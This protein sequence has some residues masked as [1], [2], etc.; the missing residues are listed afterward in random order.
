MYILIIFIEIITL[1]ALITI[2]HN[3]R[4]LKQD[5]FRAAVKHSRFLWLTGIVFNGF[6]TW[7][8]WKKILPAILLPVLL[9]TGVAI[10]YIRYTLP[11]IP[12]VPDIAIDYQDSALFK[13][14]RYLA[15]NVAIC[16]DCH[17]PRNVSYF[18]WPVIRNQK[19][20]GGPF[21][22]QKLG[23]TFPGE[24]FTPN[25]TPASLGAWTDGEI[26]R[27][28]TTGI[29]RNGYTINHVMP[30]LSYAQMDPIDIKAIIVYI[31]TLKP[32]SNKPAGITTINYFHSLYNRTLPREVKPIYLSNLKTAIDS[33][34]YLVTVAGC[35]DCHTPKKWLEINDTSR[36]LSGGIEYPLPTGGFVHSANLT[37]DQSGLGT[38][39]EST[40]I[41]KFKR[42]RDSGAIYKPA[43][44]TFNSLMPWSSYRYMTDN[45][46][47][48]IYAYLKSIKPISNPVTIF[49]TQSLKNRK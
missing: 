12:P 41:D 20:A 19:G 5:Q 39:T 45:D 40:F 28:L 8:V 4:M 17:S 2:V 46:L 48:A 37:P 25:I 14:G 10:L 29:D 9:V 21:L 38:W 7:K 1:A 33:G 35:N 42:Y 44:N 23:Y 13:R 6:L 11:K 3:L 18:S 31:R 30:F 16:I 36:K 22:S 26:Y 49:S 27:L 32:I 24:S 43:P 47:H 34:Y 15:E